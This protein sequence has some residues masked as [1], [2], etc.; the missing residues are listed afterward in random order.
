MNKISQSPLIVYRRYTEL[1]FFCDYLW[2]II[3]S[4]EDCNGKILQEC[5][6]I[7][8]K[9][10]LGYQIQ[11]MC[12]F[13]LSTYIHNELKVLSFA[14]KS[15]GII[16]NIVEHLRWSLLTQKAPSQTQDRVLNASLKSPILSKDICIL[17]VTS[18]ININRMHSY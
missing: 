16:R 13:S 18:K 4:R 1:D 2:M 17:Q 3:C 14:T 6:R 8:A 5:Y 12:F 15:R 7:S 11:M 10:L 9:L